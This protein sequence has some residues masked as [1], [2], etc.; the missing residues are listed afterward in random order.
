[1]KP[2]WQSSAFLRGVEMQITPRQET[3]PEGYVAA[4]DW[5]FVDSAGHGHFY[6]PEAANHYP[7]LT[8]KQRYCTIHA[9]CDGEGYWEC[10]LCG[11]EVAPGSVWR[12]AYAE[13]IGYDVTVV[14]HRRDGDFTYAL[15][16]SEYAAVVDAVAT[17]ATAAFDGAMADQRI[18][19]AVLHLT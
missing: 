17:A 4:V 11:E 12:P 9:D 2:P 3:L 6:D 16:E 5:R 19:D 13:T 8:H 15:N 14:L 1:M 7:T 10:K 18:V